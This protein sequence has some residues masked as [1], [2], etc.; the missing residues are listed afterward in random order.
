M[1]R[2]AQVAALSAAEEI[3]DDVPEAK[4]A[5]Y[6]ERG[7]ARHNQLLIDLPPGGSYAVTQ[8][9]LDKVDGGKQSVAFSGH[10]QV[11][12]LKRQDD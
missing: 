7:Y 3:S 11:L 1:L 2:Q 9:D 8:L 12:L 5:I 4:Q 6:N 10:E